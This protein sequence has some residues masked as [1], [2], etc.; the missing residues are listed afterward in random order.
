M[1]QYWKMFEKYMEY[2]TIFF[3]IPFSFEMVGNIYTHMHTNISKEK[4]IIYTHTCFAIIYYIYTHMHTNAT[5]FFCFEELLQYYYNFLKLYIRC[6]IIDISIFFMFYLSK[7][8]FF[9]LF[10]LQPS[11]LGN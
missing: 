2:E 9:H 7:Q 6:F 3:F 10:L 5:I 1:K 11:Y 4:G 8:M